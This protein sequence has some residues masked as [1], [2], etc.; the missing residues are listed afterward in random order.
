MCVGA[1][2]PDKGHIDLLNA[3]LEIPNSLN[4]LLAGKGPLERDLRN[5]DAFKRHKIEIR[6][7]PFEEMPTVYNNAKI[8]TLASREEAFGLVF[9][10][11][12]S[13][14]M[15]CVL[16]DIPNHR[17]VCG[18]IGFYCD[19]SN[20]K[21][22]AEKLLEALKVDKYDLNRQQAEKFSWDSISGK[23]IESMNRLLQG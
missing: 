5:H 1:F 13:T 19:V 18:S 10:E 2:T 12:L 16:N 7:F 23:Y 21:S 22:Y 20:S 8:F 3:L 14:G 17:Y 15:N 6:Q 4:V 9:L 11:A